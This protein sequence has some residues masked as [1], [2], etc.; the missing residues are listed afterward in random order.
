VWCSG[1]MRHELYVQCLRLR[2]FCTLVTHF[3]R[4]TEKS[5]SSG[6]GGCAHEQVMR[7]QHILSRVCRQQTAASALPGFLLL[8]TCSRCKFTDAYSHPLQT[9]GA[10]TPLGSCSPPD[11]HGQPECSQCIH[12]IVLTTVPADHSALTTARTSQG[13]SYT[14]SALYA[15]VAPR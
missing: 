14:M 9:H 10:I 5:T 11:Y 12:S 13:F 3:P 7:M 6:A 8:Q 4:A 1:A 15:K 2:Y